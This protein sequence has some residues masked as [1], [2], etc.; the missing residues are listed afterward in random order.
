MITANNGGI[1]GVIKKEGKKE[2]KATSDE[3]GKQ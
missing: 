2:V 1:T 3:K